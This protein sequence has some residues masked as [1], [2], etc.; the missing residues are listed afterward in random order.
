MVRTVLT[1][2]LSIHCE[3]QILN[4]LFITT[5]NTAEELRLPEYYMQS[6]P[7]LTAMRGVGVLSSLY[8]N[9][10]MSQCSLV[11]GLGR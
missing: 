5:A 7:N 8:Q 3:L 1:Q 2:R 11:Q 9:V 4:E 6:E 10:R